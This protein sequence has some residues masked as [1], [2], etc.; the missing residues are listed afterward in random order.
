VSNSGDNDTSIPAP[1]A[2]PTPAPLATPTPTPTPLATPT[3]TPQA[4]Q[5][6]LN[7]RWN[8]TL[9][10]SSSTCS[11]WVSGETKY[12]TGYVTHSGSSLKVEP[13][14]WVELSGSINANGAFGLSGT[15][16]WYTN[17]GREYWEGQ[18]TN[19]LITATHTEYDIYEAPCSATGTIT[20]RRE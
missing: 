18:A 7:G 15:C 2:T 5:L 11:N 17:S 19:T 4:E 9:V 8:F 13:S 10:I 12:W 6:D 3:P 14:Y 1:S 16:H 20:G